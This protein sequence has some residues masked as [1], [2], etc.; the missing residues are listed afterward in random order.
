MLSTPERSG[1]SEEVSESI[2]DTRPF[3]SIEP[4]VC[5]RLP[6]IS[7]S[8]VLLPAPFGPMIPIRCPSCTSNDTSRSAQKR[9]CRMPPK[10]ASMTAS[11]GLA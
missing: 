5:C 3:T 7:F 6:A 9:S 11:R 8:N 1:S 2:A 4:P 10:S